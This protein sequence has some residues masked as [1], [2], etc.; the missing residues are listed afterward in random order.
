MS[1]REQVA[2]WAA[3]LGLTRLLESLPRRGGLLVLNYHRI[4]DAQA[5]PYDRGVFSATVDEF[6]Q[7]MRYLRQRYCILPLEYALESIASGV[8]ELGVL[9][10]FDDGYRDNFTNAFPVLRD[11]ALPA[12]FFLATGFIG[13]SRLPWWDAIAYLV[14]QTPKQ[15]VTL[16]YPESHTFTLDLN[17]EQ[18]IL[19]VLR[20]FKSPANHDSD[21]FL[22]ELANA[23]GMKLPLEAPER[24]FVTWDE[25]R[26]MRVNG[27]SFGS[28]THTH[29]LLS[30]LSYEDQLAELRTSRQLIEQ[31][32]GTALETVAFPVGSRTAFD[33]NTARAMQAAGYSTGFS[34]FGGINRA[35]KRTQPFTLLREGVGGFSPEMLRLRYAMAAVTGRVVI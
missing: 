1:K 19:E 24:L 16:S 25:V 21:R 6:R 15:T 34:F 17:R 13:S 5:C 30:T 29:R 12:T 35:V 26:N 31:E 32:L 22:I 33:R 20:V 28:H 10:T 11:E 23:C 4:G 2:R 8:R 14:R 27:M 9:I 18:A 7:Q 3:W